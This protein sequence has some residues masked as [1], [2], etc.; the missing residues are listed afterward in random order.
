MGEKSERETLVFP[1]TER[2]DNRN[3]MLYTVVA[4]D[5]DKLYILLPSDIADGNTHALYHN[6]T[7][8]K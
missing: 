1:A 6:V 3:G 8:P 5:N 7:S 4:T 2:R